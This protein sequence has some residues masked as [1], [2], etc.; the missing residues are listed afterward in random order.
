MTEDLS[1][2]LS[3]IPPST[4]PGV[5]PYQDDDALRSLVD[6]KMQE[7]SRGRKLHEISWYMAILFY[8]GKHWIRYE[9]ATNR[10]REVVLRSRTP[11]PVTNVYSSTLDA[12]ISLLAR[13]EP[14]LQFPPATDEPDDQATADVCDRVMEVIEEE[15]NIRYQRQFGA[16]WNGLTGGFWF[17]TGYDNDPIHGTVFLQHDQCAICGAVQPPQSSK[18]CQGCGAGL[19]RPAQGPDG[20]IGER[21]PKGKMYVDVVPLAEMFCD[22]SVTDWKKIRECCRQKS[23]S[24]DDAKQRWPALADQIQP[25]SMLS[26]TEFYVD[27]LATMG[28]GQIDDRAGR[29]VY[30]TSGSKQNQRVTER[31]YYRLPDDTYP[32]GL[33][34]IFVGKTLKAYAG[35]LP[36]SSLNADGSRTK[37]LNFT[38]FPQKLRPGSLIPKTVATDLIPKQAQRNRLESLA[39]Q[40]AMRMA[41]PVW[42][43]PQGAGVRNMTGDAGQIIEW[44]ALGVGGTAAK[45]E[46][47]PGQNIPGTIIRMIEMIDESFEELA[48]TFTVIKGDRPEGVSAGIALQLLKERGESRFAPMFIL[49]EIGHAEWA[50]QALEIFREFATEERLLRIKGRD[51]SWEVQK[52]L[53]ADLKGRINVIPEAAS[54]FPKSTLTERAEIEQGIALGLINVGDGETR[55]LA[56]ARFNL[57]DMMPGM[58]VETKNALRENESFLRLA[59][60]PVAGL[61]PETLALAGAMPGGLEAELSAVTPSMGIQIP[62][63]KPSIDDHAIHGQVHRDFARSETGQQLP[64]AVMALLENHLLQHDQLEMQRM[65]MMMAAR[66]G[67][68]PTAG[69]LSNPGGQGGSPQNGSSSGKRMAGDEREMSATMASREG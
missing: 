62:R 54:A 63:V 41:N 44:N 34:A 69:F 49:W 47:I 1:K 8:L 24:L 30:A 55:R 31:W 23:V 20:P 28:P 36:Y 7:W 29:G 39:E 2:S 45:P 57:M 58:Q 12:F 51:G 16:V 35:P 66:G 6:R 60:S 37:F 17:E 22:W 50:V 59:Q 25:D 43:V 40:I 38:W 64:P 61:G 9:A 53:G 33:L 27:S 5:D 13:V 48:G 56:A 3:P 32:E 4:E 11:M 21:V 19:L 10:I 42:L 26:A 65:Q 18:T 67:T 52:F 15:V 46:R 68:F 14:R